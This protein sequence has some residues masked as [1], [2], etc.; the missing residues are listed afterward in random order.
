[1][2]AVKFLKMESKSERNVIFLGICL[3]QID[4]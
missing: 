3:L 4:F 2:N 1:M